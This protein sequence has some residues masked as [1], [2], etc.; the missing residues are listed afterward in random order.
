MAF[1]VRRR[2][3]MEKKFKFRNFEPA[4]HVENYANSI[5]EQITF[6]FPDGH[7]EWAFM[8][9]VREAYFCFLAFQVGHC[10][11][12]ADAISSDHTEA[13][14]RADQNLSQQLVAEQATPYEALVD[15]WRISA[16]G[17]EL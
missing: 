6:P 13:L 12:V 3:F 2:F 16:V 8:I 5:V 1:S 11:Y 17:G 14:E 7:F 10:Q 9:K 4:R 15:T